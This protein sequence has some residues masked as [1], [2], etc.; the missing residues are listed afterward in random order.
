LSAIFILSP[1]GSF[2]PLIALCVTTVCDRFALRRAPP[3]KEW[4]SNKKQAG[5]KTRIE[6][7]DAWDDD[8]NLTRTTS[9]H[10][11]TSDWKKTTEKKTEIIPAD[12]VEKMGLGRK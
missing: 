9:T 3:Q 1:V 12:M 8:G 4:E 2:C 6:I 7:E 11:T 10:I 5:D